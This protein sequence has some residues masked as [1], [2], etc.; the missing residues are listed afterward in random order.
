MTV[1]SQAKLF[2][3]P[4]STPLARVDDIDEDLES[5]EDLDPDKDE[6][7]E[8]EEESAPNA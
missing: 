6:D 4:L 8:D 1:H 2:H 7:D 5:D 3:M